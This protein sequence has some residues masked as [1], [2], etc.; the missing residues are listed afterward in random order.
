[1]C[2]LLFVVWCVL[3]GVIFAV[4]CSLCVLRC[5][6][7]VDCCCLSVVASRSWLLFIVKF[8]VVVCRVLF[9]V[10]GSWCLM[11]VVDACV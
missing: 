3:F 4:C 9:V 8:V 11:F 2:Y 5:C 6:S 10:G 1:M 7:L